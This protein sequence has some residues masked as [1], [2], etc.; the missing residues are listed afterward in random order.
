MRTSAAVLHSSAPLTFSG[1][2][3]AAAAAAD[4]SAAADFSAA[5]ACA[6][7]GALEHRLCLAAR[8]FAASACSHLQT[9]RF[10]CDLHVLSAALLLV[11]VCVQSKGQRAECSSWDDHGNLPRK[12]SQRL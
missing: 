4:L 9:P 12:Q 1:A 5:A 11:A 6:A 2:G 7:A 10:T 8:G 3:S